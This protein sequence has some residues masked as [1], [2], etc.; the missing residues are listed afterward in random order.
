MTKTSNKR[1]FIR[2]MP[3]ASPKEIVAAAEKIG[4]IFKAKYVHNVR[5]AVLD[6]LA[7][8]TVV[9]KPEPKKIVRKNVS[10]KRHAGS[11]LG[12]EFERSLHRL[13]ADVGMQLAQQALQD[14]F[15]REF[16]G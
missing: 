15:A 11:I 9:T 14:A 7:T 2:S 13:A 6:A 10:P 8:E 5:A 4:L 12:G 16:G 3:D 1:E